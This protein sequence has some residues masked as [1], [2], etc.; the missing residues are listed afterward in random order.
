MTTPSMTM[1]TEEDVRTEFGWNDDMID[2][3]LQSPDSPHVR[4]NKHTG[5]Y[6]YGLYKR[7]RVLAVAQSKGRDSKPRW[8][9]T[10]RGKHTQPRVDDTD[11]RYRSGTG[12]TAVAAGKILELLGYPSNRHV[13][14]SAVA[15]GCGVR[16]WDGV[17]MHDDWHLERAVAAIGLAAQARGDTAVADALA[18]AIGR[19]QGPERLAARKRKQM[20][21]KPCVGRRRRP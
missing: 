5:A 14:D 20:R 16:R 17:A 21:R 15:V 10:L 18:A 4:R 7:E 13:T 11:G 3:F 1:M 6:T 2:Y 8:D 12:I 19:R 9:E